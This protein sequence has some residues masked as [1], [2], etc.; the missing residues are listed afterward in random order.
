MRSTWPLRSGV[1]LPVST[2][3]NSCWLRTTSTSAK[4]ISR[5]PP[6]AGD[7]HAHAVA[8]GVERWAL[9]VFQRA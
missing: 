7:E 4:P 9:L 8:G 5:V 3:R 2:V 1:K 6:P